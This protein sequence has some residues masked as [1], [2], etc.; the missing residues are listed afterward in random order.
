MAD[1]TEKSYQKQAVISVGGRASKLF[2]QK[3]GKVGL[4]PP[5]ITLPAEPCCEWP[6]AK[7]PG[8]A[9]VRQHRVA[10]APSDCWL[11]LLFARCSATLARRNRRQSLLQKD[12]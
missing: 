10:S 9:L 4:P 12:E 11:T 6:L 2:K 5:P 7:T 8:R 1:Q 3:Q